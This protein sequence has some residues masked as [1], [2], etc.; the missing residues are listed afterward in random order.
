M[1]SHGLAV[2]WAMHMIRRGHCLTCE[3]HVED[4]VRLVNKLFDVFTIAA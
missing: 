4:E 2:L 1:K 3:P